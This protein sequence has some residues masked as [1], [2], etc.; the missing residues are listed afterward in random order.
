[1]ISNKVQ[2]YIIDN[3]L[4]K[5]GDRVAVAVSGGADSVAL[6][7][8]LHELG[9]ECEVLHCNFHL[10]DDESDRDETFV[11]HLC[12]RLDIRCHIKHFDTV[13]YAA[14]QRISIEMAA[15]ELRYAW[16]GMMLD[17]LKL[18]NVAVAHHRDDSVETM[19]L[20]L[21]RGTG[22][23]GLV[24]IEPKRGRIVRPLLGVSRNEILDYLR[25]ID[26]EYM[27]DRTNLTDV[28]LRNKIRLNV[29]PML[30]TINPSIDHSLSLTI[31]RLREVDEVYRHAMDMACARVETEQGK[32][33]VKQL[34]AEV[35]PHSVLFELFHSYG[36]NSS[37]ISDIYSGLGKEAGKRYLSADYELLLDRE[38]LLLRLREQDIPQPQ[39]HIEYFEIDEHFVVPRLNEEAYLDAD[40]LDG[41]L[42]MRRWDSNDVFIPYGMNGR[43]KVKDFLRDCKVDQFTRER[44]Q[45]VLSGTH[46]VWVVGLRIN[47][48][49]RITRKTKRV[50]RLFVTD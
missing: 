12:K 38:Y 19:I 35:A 32:F 3:N 44:Q 50:V 37:Q 26:Q 16:F 47:N 25:S 11:N 29:L 41:D 27:T 30:R 20:N 36:F 7:F 13:V 33:S 8:I 2:Q 43:K 18:D 9:F 4:L 21:I 40:L 39:L 5:R 48:A 23:R 1:M 28:Y 14:Q 31:D 22:I 45:V 17:E 6:L 24:G 15:R 42:T 49:F 10:R 34:L 46:V